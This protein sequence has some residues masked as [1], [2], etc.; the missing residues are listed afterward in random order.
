MAS[1]ESKKYIL[2]ASQ[3]K[4]IKCYATALKEHY[5]QFYSNR[6]THPENKFQVI[7]E[8][9]EILSD[10]LIAQIKFY[11][12]SEG[13]CSKIGTYMSSPVIV[14]IISYF[15][16]CLRKVIRGSHIQTPLSTFKMC[17]NCKIH[18]KNVKK[19]TCNATVYCSTTCQKADW[20]RHKT[21]CKSLCHQRPLLA[22]AITNPNQE[23]LVLTIFPNQLIFEGCPPV[24]RTQ[25]QHTSLLR[26]M[27]DVFYE[28]TKY[29]KDFPS[30]NL[31]GQDWNKPVQEFKN[32]YINSQ[33]TEGYD[34][35]N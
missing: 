19:C 35:E 21:L 4:D 32:D 25:V 30:Y 18:K 22:E 28:I 31:D 10:P 2:T 11:L 1:T 8:L 13:C 14:G 7:F 23:L 12:S 3:K 26:T 24:S 6:Y 16:R 34:D 27:N 9:P 15:N 20:N 17:S 5:I 33:I 29:F